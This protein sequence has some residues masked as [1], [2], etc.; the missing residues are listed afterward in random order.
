[1]PIL[2]LLLIAG[3]CLD[4]S[5]PNPLQLSWTEAAFVTGGLMLLAWS[6]AIALSGAVVRALRQA[7]IPRKRI[8][9]RYGKFR[10]LLFLYNLTVTALSV[11]VLGWG[12]GVWDNCTI[13]WGSREKLFPFAELLVPAPYLITLFVNWILYYPAERALHMAGNSDK[14]YW[15]LPA[16]LLFQGRMFALMVLLPV[17]LFV[18]Q[19]TFVRYFPAIVE[20]WWFHFVA[21]SGI[22]VVFIL[23]PRMLK[24]LLGLQPLPVGPVRDRYLAASKRGGV[25]LTDLLLWPTRGSVANALVVGIIPWARYVIFTDRLLEELNQEELDAVFGHE[26][27]HAKHRHLPYYAAFFMVSSVAG[28]SIYVMILTILEQWRVIDIKDIQ[29][30]LQLPPVGILALHVFIVFGFLSRVCERQAD[31]AGCRA[32]SCGNRNCTGHTSETVLVP[33]APPCPTGVQAMIRALERIV[34]LNDMNAPERKGWRKQLSTLWTWMKAW[35]HGPVKS[36]MEYLYLLRDKPEMA[37]QHDRY[38]FYLRWALMVL[39]VTAIFIGGTITGWAELAKR[40]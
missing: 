23:M 10:F 36:R 4:V 34:V 40:L 11:V 13:P 3:A 20:E 21:V 28:V 19:Q 1:M 29:P 35:Q 5:W 14:P 31:V 32:G 26:L 2:I 27:G 7:D 24:L 30:Y 15:S 18:T 25:R 37:A 9:A 33:N 22:L 6:G 8:A 17:S 38:S 16:Y 12:R 39:L